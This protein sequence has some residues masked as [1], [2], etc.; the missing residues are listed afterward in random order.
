M[1]AGV[2]GPGSPALGRPEPESLVPGT[3]GFP[4]PEEDELHRTLGVER[5]EEILQEAGSRGGEEPGRSYG[6]EDFEY[7]RQSSHHIHH[8]LSTH[9]PLDARRRKTPQGPGRKPRR[10]PGASPTGETPT[11]EEGEEDED[12]AIEAEGARALKQPSPASTPS[13][14]QVEEVVV[15]A[16]GTAGGDDGG[17][18][19]R[20]LP[21][22]QPGHRSY[23]LQE[24]RRIGSMTG[25]EQALL[26]RVPTDESEAQTLAT[27]DLDLMKS[28]RFEDVP[29]LLLPF[30][31]LP[32]FCALGLRGPPCHLMPGA[33]LLDLDQQ[34]LPG[35]AHQVVEQMVIS[36][37]IKAED[38]A[39]V[40]RALLLKHR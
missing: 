7:H 29:G 24:R 22:A 28:H 33:V 3:P 16:S 21:K 13:S 40:L 37:Q 35:V 12:E 30:H 38:R 20:P 39:N 27:A 1:A 8:P 14:V 5:F 4:E 32:L 6:E 9:L 26:P 2:R 31:S 15:V 18:S 36:D 10:R 17:A 25:A 19:G 11:I 23:N 34:T